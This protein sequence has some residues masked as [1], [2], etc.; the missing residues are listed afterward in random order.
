MRSM[1]VTLFRSLVEM[2]STL[3]HLALRWLVSECP[4]R[5][6]KVSFVVCP[7]FLFS[8]VCYLLS[9]MAPN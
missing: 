5:I 4:Q 1:R 9:V 6:P 3:G 2:G 7:G 8:A